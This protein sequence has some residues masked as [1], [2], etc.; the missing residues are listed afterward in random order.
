MKL[1]LHHHCFATITTLRLV[2]LAWACLVF[3]SYKSGVDSNRT[4]SL[5]AIIFSCRGYSTASFQIADSE[6][7]NH[8]L[9]PFPLAQA[10]FFSFL[11][12]FNKDMTVTWSVAFTILMNILITMLRGVFF[13][14]WKNVVGR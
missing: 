10:S 6:G 11:Y 13:F 7:M 3:L 12:V 5:Q 14:L 8:K 9:N 1:D 2:L 4:L